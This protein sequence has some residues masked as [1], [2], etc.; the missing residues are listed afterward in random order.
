MHHDGLCLLQV[1]KRWH[2]ETTTG[3]AIGVYRPTVLRVNVMQS[4]DQPAPVVSGGQV[5]LLSWGASRMRLFVRPP[6]WS[7]LPQVKVICCESGI[8][9][10]GKGG[11]MDGWNQ[12]A[13]KRNTFTVQ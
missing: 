12:L 9:Y 11:W 8:N 5:G 1:A 10:N 13:V 4:N 7:D 2:A 3:N 6:I